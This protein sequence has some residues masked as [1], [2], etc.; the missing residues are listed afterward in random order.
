MAQLDKKMAVLKRA[1]ATLQESV[2]DQQES[3]GYDEKR[4]NQWRDSLIQRFEYST[5]LLWKVMR[6]Y[7]QETYG[8]DPQPAPKPVFRELFTMGL[9]SEPEAALFLEIVDARNTTS[10]TYKEEF[11]DFLSKKIPGYY[12]A[13]AEL[14]RR[15]K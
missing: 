7:L 13:M 5:D 10:H 12:A 2:A 6:T 3:A 9:L 4:Y 8:A 1:L 11:A 14:V 15:L